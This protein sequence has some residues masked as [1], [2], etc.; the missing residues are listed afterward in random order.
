MIPAEQDLSLTDNVLFAAISVEN[1]QDCR[2]ITDENVC[3]ANKVLR[4]NSCSFRRLVLDIGEPRLFN[5][6]FSMMIL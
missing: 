2:F 6:D 1:G 4:V 5:A 3:M